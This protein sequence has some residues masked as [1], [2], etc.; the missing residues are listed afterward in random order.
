MPDQPLPQ[1]VI[2]KLETAWKWFKRLW[3]I[4]PVVTIYIEHNQFLSLKAKYD[5]ITQN[6]KDKINELN[7]KL[8]IKDNEI[9]A[10][11]IQNGKILLLTRSANGALVA[12]PLGPFVPPEGG[13]D[14][15][16]TNTTEGAK[17]TVIDKGF[18]FR[19]G[20]GVVYSGNFYPELDFKL[21][22]FKQYSLKV[23]A[24]FRE[25]YTG[26]IDVGI[27]RHVNDWSALS[28]LQNLEIQAVSGYNY[29]GGWRIG[30]GLRSNL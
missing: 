3:W 6:S 8:K 21:I 23:G 18:T 12:P 5:D 30:G 20:I 15:R 17:V 24:T 14:I 11:R 7:N 26:F 25:D 1:P 2:G 22:F 27:S 10:L 16:F 19:P 29:T 9:F 13:I 4:I 28:L